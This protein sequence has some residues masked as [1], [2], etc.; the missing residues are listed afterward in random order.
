M[1]KY[2]QELSVHSSDFVILG[3][4][5]NHPTTTL[6][7]RS[8]VPSGVLA[9]PRILYQFASSTFQLWVHFKRYRCCW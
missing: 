5:A 1:P 7:S 9:P 3:F 8:S 4:H 2:F 6:P